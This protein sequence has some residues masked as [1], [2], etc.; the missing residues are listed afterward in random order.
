MPEDQNAS[1]YDKSPGS[2][3]AETRM[4]ERTA[5]PVDFPDGTSV[6]LETI[7]SDQGNL[8]IA[9][10]HTEN[11]FNHGDE[12]VDRRLEIADAASTRLGC[13]PKD[14]NYF[15]QS[16]HRWANV[17]FE[18]G[19]DGKARVA[20]DGIQSRSDHQVQAAVRQHTEPLVGQNENHSP[21]WSNHLKKPKFE[22]DL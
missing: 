13:D 6:M 10:R 21:E 3:Q 14:L 16:D 9:S 22:P 5:E 17:T 18:N 8:A 12:L 19:A 20:L 15:E 7:K 4:V 1:A 11:P 2:E